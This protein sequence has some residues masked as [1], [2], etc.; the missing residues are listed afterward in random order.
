MPSKF[1]YNSYQVNQSR[2]LRVRD[3]QVFNPAIRRSLEGVVVSTLRE[4]GVSFVK[5]GALS[6]A[7]PYGYDIRIGSV[8]YDF[9]VMSSRTQ[10]DQM[11]KK[12]PRLP[13]HRRSNA[14][15]GAV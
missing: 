9:K 14:S 11:R 15:C 2:T 1:A 6:S 4:M 13:Y 10:V 7:L 12:L 3:V 8:L 5:G